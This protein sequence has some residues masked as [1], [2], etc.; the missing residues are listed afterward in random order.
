MYL[1]EF[2]AE[3]FLYVYIQ[4]HKLDK[5]NSSEFLMFWLMKYLIDE[6]SYNCSEE[7]SKKK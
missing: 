7:Y 5:S 3:T 6:L 1:Y 4:L 2:I